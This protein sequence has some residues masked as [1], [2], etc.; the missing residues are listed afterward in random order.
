[1]LTDGQRA[2]G[3][4]VVALA[5]GRIAS[6]AWGRMMLAC[7][8]ARARARTR[9]QRALAP[10]RAQ[11]KPLRARVKLTVQHT[12]RGVLNKYLGGNPYPQNPQGKTPSARNRMVKATNATPDDLLG[13]LMRETF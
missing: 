3:G 7:R 4:R 12:P 9:L 11:A 6:R 13:E 2:A 8:H 1:M 5:Y 10:M